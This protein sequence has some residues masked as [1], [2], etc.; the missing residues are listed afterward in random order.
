VTFEMIDSEKRFCECH[1]QTFCR[2]HANHQRS[3][4]PGSPSGGEGVNLFQEQ[5]GAAERA[6]DCRLDGAKMIPRSDL[7]NDTAVW[8]VK[9]SLRGDFAAEQRVAAKNGNGR[10]VT[11]RFDREDRSVHGQVV[12]AL[13]EPRKSLSA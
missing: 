12:A 3:R 13:D 6:R 4:Q 10:F 9:R 2:G 1:G 7:G 8:P 5:T 11:G